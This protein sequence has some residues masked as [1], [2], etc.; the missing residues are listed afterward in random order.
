MPSTWWLM[1]AVVGLTVLLG[2]AAAE[3]VDTDQCRTPSSCHEDTVKLSLTGVWV[4]QA[5]VAAFAVLAVAGEYGTGMVRV[6]L[7][8]IPDRLRVLAAKASVVGAV[9]AGAALVAIAGSVLVGQFL[10]AGNGFTRANGY[11]PLSFTDGPTA[12]AV[13]GSVAYLVLIALLSVGVAFLVRDTAGAVGGVLALLYAFPI[14]ASLVSDDTWKE[15]L[16]RSAPASAG[17]AIQ[18]TRDLDQL[19]IG[20]WAGL[21][22]LALYAAG[23]LVAG[24]AALWHRDA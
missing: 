14:A 10:L 4:G 17:L 24:G 3:G 5:A 8:A 21:G 23:A 13:F 16:T 1:F 18:S 19:A 7:T 2:A 11:A 12:R 20:P 15:W 9:T 22:V 6:T